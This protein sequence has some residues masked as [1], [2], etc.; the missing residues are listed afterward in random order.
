MRN[1]GENRGGQTLIVTRIPLPSQILAIE[2]VRLHK[3]SSSRDSRNKSGKKTSSA[4]FSQDGNARGGASLAGIFARAQ[5]YQPR[6]D[7]GNLHRERLQNRPEISDMSAG[8]L[9]TGTRRSVR[10]STAGGL[11]LETNPAG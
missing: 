7:S 4:L 6:L 11:V 3:G 8:P 5:T 9:V 1:L 2:M 10:C